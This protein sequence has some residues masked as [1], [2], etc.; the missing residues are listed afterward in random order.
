MTP[1]KIQKKIL[2]K[3]QESCCMEEL[4]G[5]CFIILVTDDDKNNNKKPAFCSVETVTAHPGSELHF[6]LFLSLMWMEN[7][8]SEG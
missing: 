3:S 8:L 2:Y 4:P 6:S 1:L 7:D 5:G